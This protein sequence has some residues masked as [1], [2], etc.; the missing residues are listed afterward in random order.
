MEISSKA[1]PSETREEELV[2]PPEDRRALPPSRHVLSPCGGRPSAVR[3]A[4]WQHP[5]F[6]TQLKPNSKPTGPSPSPLSP[7][8]QRSSWRAGARHAAFPALPDSVGDAP[9][10]DAVAGL[11]HGLRLACLPTVAAPLQGRRPSARHPP[12]LRPRRLP[13][14]TL[15]AGCPALPPPPCLPRRWAG[16]A[17]RC[18][19]VGAGHRPRHSTLGEA[20]KRK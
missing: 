4:A 1:F 6:F 13:S 12:V 8:G 18:P 7:W 11:R 9:D 3:R 2:N 14:L 15:L 20:P 5:S 10:T 17:P 19:R 16:A